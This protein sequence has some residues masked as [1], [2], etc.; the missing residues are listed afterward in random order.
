MTASS[1][2]G[3]G[4][5]MATPTPSRIMQIGMGFWASKA[6]LTA[7]QFDLFTRL[8]PN[9]LSA[10]EIREELGLRCSERHVF[11]WLDSLVTLGLLQRTGLWS[12]AR[13]AN[14]EDTDLF[15]DKNKRSY[16][17]GIL[18]M[19]NSRLY[20]FWNDL[21]E[22][23]KTGQPQNESKGSP[24]GNMAFFHELY[25]DPQRLQEFMDAMG[26][27]QAGN[28][29]V[30]VNSFDFGRF[31]T[32][33]DVGGADASLS[34]QVCRRFPAIRSVSFDLPPVAPL[35]ARNIAAAQLSD[36]ISAAG[37]DFMKDPWPKADLVTMGNILHGLDEAGKQQLVSTA[38]NSLADG[39][40]LLAIE[41]IIDNDRRQNLFGLLM[42]L[43]MLIE[44]GDAFD[45][46]M[47][48]F[49]R[50]TKAAGFRRTE[51][52]PLAGPTSAAVAYK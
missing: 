16:M 27:I 11:D 36:R 44:N 32:M 43:N 46:T 28:F 25:Q 51:R 20:R 29:M 39:G 6:L 41:N 3:D 18:E 48:D 49:E 7:V 30:L 15:L 34:I 21:G 10:R 26:G 33:L 8:A 19:A 17:G 45:Y 5:G 22:G 1:V 38:Y 9:P 2:S 23:L 31:A 24:Q 4:K 12:T 50:W 14:A 13:Y 47:N 40:A 42:S 52:I 35:A 37:G